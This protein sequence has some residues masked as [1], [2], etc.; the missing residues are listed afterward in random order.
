MFGATFNLITHVGLLLMFGTPKNGYL[1]IHILPSNNCFSYRNVTK[2]RQS[3]VKNSFEKNSVFCPKA[4]VHFGPHE[5]VQI[6]P[7][8]AVEIRSSVS[9][10]NSTT[11]KF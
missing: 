6:L 7:A 2:W 9:I 1:K 10:C 11:E 4:F 3:F 5:W 8:Y